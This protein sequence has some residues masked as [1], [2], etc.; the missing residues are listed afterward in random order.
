MSG[1]C[2]S[3]HTTS[4][5]L[6][7]DTSSSIS[8]W[9]GRAPVKP[10]IPIENAKNMFPFQFVGAGL[11]SISLES[12]QRWKLCLSIPGTRTSKSG[13][14][15]LKV[16]W[17]TGW[18]GQGMGLGKHRFFTIAWGVNFPRAGSFNP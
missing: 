10:G 2:P 11:Y 8:E 7:P 12:L 5:W 18:Q 9:W 1:H 3:T 14:R 13:S 4:P 15:V 17:N 16:A 6:S